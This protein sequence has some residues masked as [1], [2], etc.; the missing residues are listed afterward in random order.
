MA[1]RQSV[2][3]LQRTECHCNGLVFDWP[4]GLKHWRATPTWSD[5]LLATYTDVC[6]AMGLPFRSAAWHATPN[7]NEGLKRKCSRVG[8][9]GSLKQC[10]VPDLNFAAK[11]N[12]ETRRTR[13]RSP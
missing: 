1:G 10:P 12:P 2:S 7:R 8:Q 13:A 11:I 9:A 5:E 4:A 3:R 6:N